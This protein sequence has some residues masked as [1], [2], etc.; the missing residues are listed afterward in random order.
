MLIPQEFAGAGRGAD[1][2]KRDTVC[3]THDF[4]RENAFACKDHG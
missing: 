3:R 1:P 2:G 4:A